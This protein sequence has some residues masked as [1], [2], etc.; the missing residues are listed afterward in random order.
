[1]PVTEPKLLDTDEPSLTAR[2]LDLAKR[3]VLAS[4]TYSLLSFR[5]ITNIFSAPQY[6]SDL[7]DQMNTIGVGSLP[8]AMV[9]GLFI[10]AVTVLQTAAQ[11]ARYGETALTGEVVAIGLVR[12][13]GPTI[14][15]L[16]V[17]GRNSSGMASELGSML[18]TEQVDAI[19]AMGTDPS[20]KLV[21]PRVLATVLV[22]PLLVALADF[23][24]S[25]TLVAV[26]L[27][28]VFCVTFGEVNMPPP[29]IIPAVAVH[30][31]CVR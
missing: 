27:T 16:L 4:Q 9:S 30:V 25:A 22:L 24:G 5:S 15:G 14:T 11:F 3:L 18:V 8:I 28:V 2:L 7:F 1:M 6:I 29:E 21:T 31:T 10:G 17:A 12:E 20:R 23:V 26:M 19:R 13:L